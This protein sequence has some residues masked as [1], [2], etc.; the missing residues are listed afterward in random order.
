[1]KKLI[2]MLMALLL[3][4]CLLPAAALADEAPDASAA[5][6]EA[7]KAPAADEAALSTDGVAIRDLPCGENLTCTLDEN[8]VLTIRGTGAMYN[9]SEDLPW[10]YYSSS[11]LDV[12]TVIL[13]D[14]V[15]SI[16]AYAFCTCYYMTSV[17]IPN[18]V[19]VIGGYAFA[20][21]RELTSVVIPESVKRICGSA[22]KNCSGLQSITLPSTV[23]L[24]GTSIFEGCSSLTSITLPDDM[25]RIEMNTFYNCTN[26]QSITIPSSVKYILSSA[27][28]ACSS[29]TSITIPEGVSEIDFSAFLIC[30]NLRTVYLPSTLRRVGPSAFGSEVDD[31]YYA[32]TREDWDKID[33]ADFAVDETTRLH[34]VDDQPWDTP[35]E[36]EDNVF[37]YSVRRDAD[38]P[39]QLLGSEYV[40]PGESPRSVPASSGTEWTWFV[41]PDLG[42]APVDP[43]VLGI[44]GRRDVLNF[45]GA[46]DTVRIYLNYTDAYGAN[47]VNE[48]SVFRGGTLNQNH[49]CC[50]LPSGCYPAAWTDAE[51]N[52]IGEDTAFRETASLYAVEGDFRVIYRYGQ[53]QIGGEG[54]VEP[55]TPRHVPTQYLRGSFNEHGGFEQ[56]SIN[57]V[58]WVDEDGNP[59]EPASLTITED[60]TFCAVLRNESEPAVTLNDDGT[61]A[62]IP[63]GYEDL[64]AR[65][66]LVIDNNGESGLYITQCRI[67]DGVVEI[68][69]FDVPGLTVTGVSVALVRN[70]EDITS[71]K[72]DA[73]LMSYKFFDA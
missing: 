40:E 73:V 42:D 5:D 22:F 59:V 19:E 46:H 9:Y 21:C 44:T 4:A 51:G 36:P 67:S 32:G 18:T 70:V 17:S 13:E 62:F 64:Y 25:E 58:G 34:F 31:I 49:R 23:E 14:G 69:A 39:L 37:Y 66:S 63:A 30:V 6:A 27:F 3:C 43:E 10:R 2:C 48:L 33:F 15:T 55:G 52:I 61:K 1:M 60:R 41:S 68:P 54:F 45:Y 35:V 72:P 56:K 65:V 29:L 24:F 53:D 26:L 7:A 47:H 50:V 11:A 71:P 8:G 16:C 20:N 12:R 28:C 38:E 57:I